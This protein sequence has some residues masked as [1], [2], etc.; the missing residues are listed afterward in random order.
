MDL[1]VVFPQ[2]VTAVEKAVMESCLRDLQYPKF[3]DL[4]TA[5]KWKTW[6]LN[7]IVVQ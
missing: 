6:L 3:N 4:Q 1:V 7:R 2:Y 5:E